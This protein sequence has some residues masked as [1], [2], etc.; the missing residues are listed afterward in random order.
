VGLADNIVPKGIAMLQYADDRIMLIQDDMKQARNL[1]PLL[2]IFEAMSG[3][4]IN[5]EKSEV[6]MIL[7]DD[8]K[9]QCYSDLFNC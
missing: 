1:E 9:N 2:Y 8:N 7:Q 5:L 3:L 4:K 6:M